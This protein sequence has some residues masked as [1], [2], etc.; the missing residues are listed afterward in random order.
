MAVFV[1]VV[2]FAGAVTGAVRPA[3]ARWTAA[4][5]TGLRVVIVND[6]AAHERQG[7]EHSQELPAQANEV[8]HSGLQIVDGLDWP[9]CRARRV[10]RAPRRMQTIRKFH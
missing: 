5:S 7:D 6:K 1:G 2:P 4:T 3:V 9:T 8:L 10:D